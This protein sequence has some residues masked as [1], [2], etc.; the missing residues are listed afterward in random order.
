MLHKATAL[1]ELTTADLD[2]AT[3]LVDIKRLESISVE[4]ECL[5]ASALK[6][7]LL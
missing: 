6:L 4:L 1:C 3:I 7:P 2:L 5:I